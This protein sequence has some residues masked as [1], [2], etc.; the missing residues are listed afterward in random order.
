MAYKQASNEKPLESRPLYFHFP[1]Y[2]HAT[3]PHSS[4]IEGDYKLIR[5]YN[6]AEGR[7]ALFNLKEDISEEYDLSDKHP[8]IVADLDEKL[9][10]YLK[11]ADAEFPIPV[12]SE[13]GKEQVEKYYRGETKG[14]SVRGA[15]GWRIQNKKS[16]R[17]LADMERNCFEKMIEGESCEFIPYS[18]LF[19]KVEVDMKRLEPFLAKN[20]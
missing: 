7:Y 10:A 11:D 13:K 17:V 12:D 14:F 3:S 20:K 9:A 16:E 5:Y 1:H 18:K 8:E 4:I 2:T 6:D 19:D 15:N